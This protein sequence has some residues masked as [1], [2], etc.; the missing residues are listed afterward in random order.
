MSTKKLLI[1]SLLLSAALVSCVHKEEMAPPVEDA[2]AYRFKVED[3][4]LTKASYGEDHI[5]FDA[6]DQVG[7]Y[8]ATSLNKSTP[9][10]V[11]DDGSKIITIR[12]SVALKAG[13][14]VYAYYPHSSAN[15]KASSTNVTLEIPR[16]QV[17]GDADAAVAAED[18]TDY[19]FE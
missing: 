17:S 16:N 4:A 3:D 2:Y 10:E 14:K 12:S 11:A 5:V 19:F 1:S 13:D 9:V 7:S 18:E 8:A 6:E 15:D